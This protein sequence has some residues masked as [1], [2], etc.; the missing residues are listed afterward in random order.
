MLKKANNNGTNLG[1]D[2]RM[3][4]SN[5]FPGSLFA[6]D[7]ICESI[8]ESPDWEAIDAV[9]LDN[10]ETS[11]RE[12]F[13]RFPTQQTPNESQTEDDLIWPVLGQLGWTVSLRQQ[14]LSAYAREDVPDGLLFADHAAK[15]R[16]NGFA[17][18]WRRYEFG[19]AVVESK[20]WGRPLDRRSASRGRG[21]R[22]LDS[23][24][25]LSSACG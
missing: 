13:E 18:E 22:A 21:H 15:D 24:A 25:P 6:N 5:P 14:N 1:F 7:Y 2:R 17:E 9:A 10:F 19:L 3:S 11:L 4:I 23:D 8:V 20:R 16:A 12:V